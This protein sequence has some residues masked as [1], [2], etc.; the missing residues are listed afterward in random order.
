MA[1]TLAYIALGFGLLG[2]AVSGSYLLHRALRARR[3]R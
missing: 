1:D 2:M 3:T